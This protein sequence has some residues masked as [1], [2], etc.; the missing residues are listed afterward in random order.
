ME[1]SIDQWA[2][3][4]VDLKNALVKISSENN[5]E[6]KKA[7]IW[8]KDF[9]R[10]ISCLSVENYWSEVAKEISKEKEVSSNLLV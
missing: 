10:M 3:A 1:Y 4:E 6:G 9:G 7:K 5:K 8:L 2:Q